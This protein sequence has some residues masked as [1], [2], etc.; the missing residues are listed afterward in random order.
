MKKIVCDTNILIS[1]LIFPGG[2]PDQVIKLAQMGKVRLFTSPA[3][4]LEFKKVMTN[5]FKLSEQRINELIDTITNFATIV[6]PKEKISVIR[7]KEDDNRILECAVEGK[8]DYIIS[9]D[10]HHILPLRKYKGIKILRASEFL[11]LK[12]WKN[13]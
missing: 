7:Q 1:A 10:E 2:K 9:G 13:K 11:N 8:C 6:K 4:L 12:P 3:I 5:K